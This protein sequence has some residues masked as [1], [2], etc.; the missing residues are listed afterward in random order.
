MTV[1]VSVPWVKEASVV[2]P[3]A[4]AVVMMSA[5]L[6]QHPSVLDVHNTTFAAAIPRVDRPVTEPE[7]ITSMRDS[8]KPTLDSLSG[9]WTMYATVLSTP[10]PDIPSAGEVASARLSVYVDSPSSTRLAPVAC[11]TATAA[12]AHARISGRCGVATIVAPVRSCPSSA[13]ITSN[14]QPHATEEERFVADV[15]V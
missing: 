1:P 10:V 12:S 11:V 14:L 4:S 5:V 6:V 2:L 13:G 9:E 7:P 15:S 3:P 8:R